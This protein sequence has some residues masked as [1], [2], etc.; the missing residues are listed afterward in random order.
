MEMGNMK[1]KQRKGIWAKLNLALKEL[2][3]NRARRE[4]K[5]MENNRELNEIDEQAKLILF[6][7]V[8]NC[9]EGNSRRGNRHKVQGHYWDYSKSILPNG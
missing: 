5:R 9:R 4:K 7:S 8:N 1:R 2:L 6:E 3:E